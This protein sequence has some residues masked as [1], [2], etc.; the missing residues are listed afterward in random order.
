[1]AAHDG[2]TIR[3]ALDAFGLP[4]GEYAEFQGECD[5]YFEPAVPYSSAS[6]M[7]NDSYTL[8]DTAQEGAQAPINSKKAAP[9][10]SAFE[11]HASH[12][13]ADASE[14]GTDARSVSTQHEVSLRPLMDGLLS[15]GSAGHP[16]LCSKQCPLQARPEGCPY[17]EACRCCHLAHP[18][19]RPGHLGERH[20]LFLLK[21]EHAERS[22]CLLSMLKAKLIEIDSSAIS[23]QLFNDL[24]A[25]CLVD[26]GQR[27]ASSR[28]TSLTRNT[29][30][31][32][33]LRAMNFKQL[34]SVLTRYT[35]SH[36][37]TLEG[38]ANALLQ[39]CMQVLANDSTHR[40]GE[41][42]AVV[43]S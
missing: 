38:A 32:N 10:G 37:P 39:H 3:K 20:R 25:A 16:L 21:A 15:R 18:N 33:I 26:F 8:S 23:E 1:M 4:C 12:S 30:L 9:C 5:M 41:V 13:G 14:N 40:N 27:P 36:A 34:L 43:Q 24:F 6:S 31:M 35:A 2:N 28:K 22:E 19:I 42:A 7:D 29:G 17:G 11:P